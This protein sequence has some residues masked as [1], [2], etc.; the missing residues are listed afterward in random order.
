MVMAN[1][2]II[3]YAMMRNQFIEWDE[4]AT[5]NEWASSA[6]DRRPLASAPDHCKAIY[7]V[8][9]NEKK[10]IIQK[11]YVT[12]WDAKYKSDFKDLNLQWVSSLFKVEAHDLHQLDNPEENIIAPGGQIIFVLEEDLRVA[13]T[14]AMVLHDDECQLAK[15]TVR[16]EHQGKGYAHPLMR[17]GIA[18][19][20]KE[21]HSEVTLYSSVNL[22]KAISLYKKHG[23]V[24]THLG[25][26][27][28]Y[29]R[30]SIIMQLKL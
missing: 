22:D 27:P 6:L 11:L 4:F 5:K 23:F 9:D 24:T 30:C 16:E 25:P 20:R 28:S 1:D 8:V 29:E 18:W 15:M 19:A 7:Y 3:T 12:T 17:E 10:E 13:G 26:H 2:T 21:G 14:V